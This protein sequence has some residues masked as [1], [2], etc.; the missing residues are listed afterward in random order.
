MSEKLLIEDFELEINNSILSFQ[1]LKFQ[2]IENPTIIF[3]HDS[4]GCIQLW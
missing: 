1:S 4:L 2:N 3:L